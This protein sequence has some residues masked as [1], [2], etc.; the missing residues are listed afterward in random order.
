MHMSCT[1]AHVC[2]TYETS[3]IY[4]KIFINTQVH[5]HLCVYDVYL[6]KSSK[7]SKNFIMIHSRSS[8]QSYIL[9]SLSLTHIS[10]I[11]LYVIVH[12]CIYSKSSKYLPIHDGVHSNLLKSDLLY[13]GDQFEHLKIILTIIQSISI[14]HS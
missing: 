11:Y 4:T 2:K 5:M 12:V 1:H 3:V 9:F 10:Y 13:T 7:S 14:S 8:S 6:S